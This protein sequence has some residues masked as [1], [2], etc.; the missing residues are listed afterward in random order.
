VDNPW[1]RHLPENCSSFLGTINLGQMMTLEAALLICMI[2]FIII[3]FV[4]YYFARVTFWSS[5]AVACLFTIIFLMLL[6]LPVLLL[7]EKTSWQTLLYGLIIVLSLVYLFFYILVMGV[8]DYRC[9]GE[10][11][12]HASR[13]SGE[14]GE[15]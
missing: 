9:V 6:Y 8:T 2:I 14:G 10:V 15:V 12:H 13:C 1:Q 7:A 11:R 4:F 3:L 5:L